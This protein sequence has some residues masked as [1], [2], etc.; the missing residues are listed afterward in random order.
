M[1][2]QKFVFYNLARVCIDKREPIGSKLLSK[3]IKNKLSPPMLRIYLRRLVSAGYIENVP[4]FLGRLPTPKGWYAYIKKFKLKAEKRI[5]F[6]FNRNYSLDDLATFTRN[7]IFNTSSLSSRFTIKGLKYIIDDNKEGEI[8]EDI[9]NII[10]NLDNLSEGFKNNRIKILIGDRFCLSQTKKISLIGYRRGDFIIG[11][12]GH[13]INC[14]HT[15][16]I[17][18]KKLFINNGRDSK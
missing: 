4:H 11:F 12:L 17:L 14:Y 2:K 8:V 15:N 3:K 7:V 1:K 10:E 6:E 16:I 13:Q 9:L 18:L 5:P